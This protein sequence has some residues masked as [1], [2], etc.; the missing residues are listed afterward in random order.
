ME[1][2]REHLNIDKWVVYGGSW[3]S[4]LSLAYAQAHPERVKALVLRGIF[5]LRRHELEFFYQVCMEGNS[6]YREW[7]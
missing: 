2:L 6:V 1:K 4:T 7:L 3:G 5:M